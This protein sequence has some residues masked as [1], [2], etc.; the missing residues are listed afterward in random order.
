[1]P[2]RFNKK[3]ATTFN[4]VHRAHDDARFYDDEASEHVLVPQS[5][6]K[7]VV[8]TTELEK[9][10]ANTNIRD[11]EGLA[12][13]YGITY[14]DSKYDYMQHL[15]PMGNPDGVFVGAKQSQPKQLI[16]DLFKDQ[17]PSKETRKVARDLNQNIPDELQGFNPNLDPRLREVLEALDDEA[18]I[19]EEDEGGDEDIFNSL[20][21][22]GEVEDEEEFYEEADDYDDEWDLDNYEEEYDAKYNLDTP[23]GVN[24]NWQRDFMQFKKDNKNKHNDW[25]SIP[26]TNSIT[27]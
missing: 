19:E 6:K 7:K 15:K 16:E 24:L 20:L 8:T 13:Q 25:D 1:M 22:S 23:E 17:L 26:T 21:Q 2:R 27:S 12:A 11:N 4:V 9:K 10:L 14:D 3:T 5:T 18:Y